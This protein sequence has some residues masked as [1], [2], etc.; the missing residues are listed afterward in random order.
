MR[1]KKGF[2]LIE[3]LVVISIIAV[4]ASI[5]LPVVEKAREHARRAVC[6]NN[7]KQLGLVL[8]IYA[9]DWYGWFPY[10]DHVLDGTVPG[11]VDYWG[12]E[13]YPDCRTNVSL[14]LLTGQT[15]PS[16]QDYE[17][18][19][20]VTDPKL[21]ICP[22]AKDKPSETGYLMTVA[23]P[24]A[25]SLETTMW[26]FG[27]T[28]S[29]AYAYGLNI[30]HRFE[31]AIMADKKTSQH[32]PGLRLYYSNAH[33]REGLNV[34]YTRGNVKWIPSYRHTDGNDYIPQDA[35]PNTRTKYATRLRN[36][37]LWY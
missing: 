9:Q 4:L 1:G 24:Q 5:L 13:Q 33:G 21:F 30:A 29:Y 14:A 15:D 17:T 18:P 28:C 20:Y 35:V 8:T 7:L 16:T 37:W 31:S 22:S 27:S 36:L 23:R 34:L 2:T 11:Y 25:G 32:W 3:L 10:H 12:V 26:R 6:M 19:R